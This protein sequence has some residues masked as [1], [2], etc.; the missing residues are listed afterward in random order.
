MAVRKKAIVDMPELRAH[1]AGAIFGAGM[2][3]HGGQGFESLH[4]LSDWNLF[5]FGLQ[6]WINCEVNEVEKDESLSAF[7]HSRKYH[8]LTPVIEPGLVNEKDMT[9]LI[10]NTPLSEL[11]KKPVLANAE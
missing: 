2:F 5:D 7:E 1:Q 6:V 4:T 10:W 9:R 8:T 3:I 11:I